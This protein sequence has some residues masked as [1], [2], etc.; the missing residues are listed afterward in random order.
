MAIKLAINGFG[1][2]GRC[3]LRAALSRKEDLEIVAINDLDK[4]SALAHLF[5]YDSVHRTWP[6][7]VSHTDKGIVV[8]GK[9]IAVTA[10]KDPSALPWKNMNVDVVMECTGRFTARDAA[11][12]HLAA[13][14]KKVIISAPAKGP[15]LTIA[16]GINQNEYDPAKHHIVSNA[17]CTTNC[18]APIAKV[19][20]D[21]FGI[22][23]GLMT[24]VHSYTNDQRI[25]DL[26]HEDMRRARAAALSMIPTSTGAAKAIGEVIPS[27]KGKMHGISVRVPT[28]NVSLVDLTVN[29][30]KKVT[31]EE[32]IAAMK[33]AANGALKGVLEFSD[34]QTVS[35]DYNGNPHSAIFDATNCFVMGDNM[36]KVMAWYDNEWGFSNRMVDTAKFLVSKGVA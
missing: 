11:A 8:N 23:K 16:Y 32:V 26:T 2:I 9:E 30:T 22:E 14:A 4:P 33:A 5:K 10:E 13:G 12:K 20:V 25:L 3:I 24:T 21:N 29:T 34:A 17:S 15:D 31:A 19:L 18:L 1:R 36:V 6:G 35:V 7:E 28:P 27:L